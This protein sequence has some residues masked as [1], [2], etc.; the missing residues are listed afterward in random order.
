[1]EQLDAAATVVITTTEQLE[2]FIA[3]HVLWVRSAPT[4]SFEEM[5]AVYPLRR[6]AEAR[7]AQAKE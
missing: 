6:D 3:E 1:L 5:R 4:L 7:K 2:S